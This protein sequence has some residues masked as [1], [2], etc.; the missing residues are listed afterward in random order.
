MS[1]SIVRANIGT[2]V[3][4]DPTILVGS[5]L[6]AWVQLTAEPLVR[7]TQRFISSLMLEPV[8]QGFFVMTT[9]HVSE[10]SNIPTVPPTQ[11]SSVFEKFRISYIKWK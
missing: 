8:I 5:N 2:F 10:H 9:Y 1:T 6:V 11:L 7:L 4:C 3:G